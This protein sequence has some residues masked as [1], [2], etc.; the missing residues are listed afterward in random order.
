M[1]VKNEQGLEEA[2]RQVIHHSALQYNYTNTNH[3]K[4]W[5]QDMSSL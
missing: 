1:W 5:S 2:D 3:K 4:N